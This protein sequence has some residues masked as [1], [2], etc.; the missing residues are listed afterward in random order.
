MKLKKLVVFDIETTMTEPFRPI[1]A[2]IGTR[3]PE[4]N[5]EFYE[6][7]N[8]FADALIAAADDGF[9]VAGFNSAGFDLKV[10]ANALPDRA[11][12][13]KQLA[14]DHFDP[15]AALFTQKG[16]MIGLDKIA[17]GFGLRSKVSHVK[18]NDG[19]MVEINGSMI[20]K[21]WNSG[22]IQAV[23]AYLYGDVI[24]EL[25]V[26]E[27]IIKTGNVFWIAKSGKMT[28]QLVCH[29]GKALSLEACLARPVPDTSWMK[30]ENGKEPW[31]RERFYGWLND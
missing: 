31:T 13:I 28:N 5:V 1:I 19:R 2:A 8:A 17:E 14:L 18:L 6:D 22:E 27:Q 21:L 10:L 12:E 30:P 9:T 16:F 24:A 20:E 29:P 26:I 3:Y 4:E 7:M 11:A 23:K 25:D 15:A